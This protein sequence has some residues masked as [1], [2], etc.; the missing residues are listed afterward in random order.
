MDFKDR[1][2]LVTI[3]RSDRVDGLVILLANPKGRLVFS[4]ERRG[5]P[6]LPPPYFVRFPDKAGWEEG[7]QREIQ[8]LTMMEAIALVD[9]RW[10]AGAWWE[11]LVA[12]DAAQRT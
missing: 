10:P 6:T 1:W 12:E 9:A 4:D 5:D 7:R 8:A 2:P 11:D 3:T